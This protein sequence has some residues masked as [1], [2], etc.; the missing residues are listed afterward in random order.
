MLGEAVIAWLE[1][2]RGVEASAS[3]E[4]R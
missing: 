1:L 3:P 4:R 2:L